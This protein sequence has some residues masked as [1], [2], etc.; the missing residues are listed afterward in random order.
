MKT[1]E[2][3]IIVHVMYRD[4]S[5]Y[6]TGED[7]LFLNDVDISTEDFRKVVEDTVGF[8]QPI[9]VQDYGLRSLSPVE[10]E[11]VPVYNEVDHAYCEITDVASTNGT[12]GI[13][14]EDEKRDP[15]KISKVISLLKGEEKS[16]YRDIHRKEE[17]LQECKEALK[18]AGYFTDNLWS[19][20]DVKTKFDVD[21]DKAQEIL[22]ET[23]ANPATYDQIWASMEVA[24]KVGHKLKLK[25]ND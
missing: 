14:K 10:N 7:Q 5:N 23:F 18:K 25:Q 6:K 11:F 12:E 24:G 4:G 19:V 13:I 15:M 20:E 16:E 1:V 17:Y 2:R 9:M 8:Y 21:D 3:I 22:Y